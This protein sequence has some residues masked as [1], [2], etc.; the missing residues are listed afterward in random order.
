MSLNLDINHPWA[1]YPGY[2]VQGSYHSFDIYKKDIIVAKEKID[3]ITKNINCP[4]LF[5]LGIGAAMDEI[6][7]S[8][9]INKQKFDLQYYQLM[10]HYIEKY[11]CQYPDYK[12]YIFI[13]SPNKHFEDG[14]NYMNPT[15]IEFTNETYEW[16]LIEPKHYK[17]NIC[18]IEVYVFCTPMPH[19]NKKA[20]DIKINSLKTNGL[21][22]LYG[23]KLCQTNADLTFIEQFYKSLSLLFNKINDN[24]GLVTCLSSAVFRNLN[25]NQYTMFSEIIKLFH[26]HSGIYRKRLLMEW[27]YDE[28]NFTAMPYY[29]ILSNI[30][31]GPFTKKNTFEI[32]FI[33]KTISPISNI[34]DTN[35]LDMVDEKSM[36]MHLVKTKHDMF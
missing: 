21:Y 12:C 36:T 1:M 25:I 19:E 14:D 23:K 8:D 16:I 34:E 32:E 11:I 31:Y 9:F 30:N 4:T 18:N 22:E 20:I 15:F 13:I 10:P 33:L 28:N 7:R 3:Q 29:N 5:H 27:I 17:S 35:A 26:G 24:N 6:Y 2:P